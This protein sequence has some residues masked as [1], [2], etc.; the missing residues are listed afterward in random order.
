MK[1]TCS[2]GEVEI[3]V[4]GEGAEKA[5]KKDTLR[6]LNYLGI[7]GYTAADYFNAKGEGDDLCSTLAEE[8]EELADKFCK[9]CAA[10]GCYK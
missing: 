5:N 4:K 8:F 9:V 2:F 6:F 10:N 7:M 1:L 3:K